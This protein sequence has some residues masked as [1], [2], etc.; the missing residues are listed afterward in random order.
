MKIYGEALKRVRAEINDL[1]I[2]IDI[3][4]L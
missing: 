4:E 2:H 1:K 3:M